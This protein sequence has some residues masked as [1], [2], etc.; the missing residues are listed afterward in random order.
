MN[1]WES[2][3]MQ[4]LQEQNLLI[5]EQTNEPNPL[6]ALYNITQH[7]TQLDKDSV[8]TRQAQ[9]QHQHT[10]ESIIK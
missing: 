2:F 8:R 9:Q 4:V 1:C 7:I 3:Y 5:K 10:G 6:Y